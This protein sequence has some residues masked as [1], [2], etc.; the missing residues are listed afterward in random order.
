MIPKIIH[1]CWVGGE[2]PLSL[3]NYRKSIVTRHPKWL[4]ILWDDPTI[5]E[6]HLRNTPALSTYCGIS[7]Y[8]RLWVV[9]NFGGIYLDTDC[10][11]VRPLDTLLIF[12]AFTGEYADVPNRVCPAVFG[13]EPQHSWVKWQLDNF[14]FQ[15]GFPGAPVD[16]MSRAPRDGVTILP[17]RYFYPY[18]WNAEPNRG[19]EDTY[20]IHHWTKLWDKVK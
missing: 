6:R 14:D 16:L 5:I 20:V 18:R 13:S 7:S 15:D 9:Y 12:K 10:E 8:L 3:L 1:Q 17:E 2:M 11:C 19:G 4:C